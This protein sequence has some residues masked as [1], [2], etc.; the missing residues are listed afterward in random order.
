MEFGLRDAVPDG[1]LA[2][3]GARWIVTQDGTVDM[4][5]DRQSCVGESKE[6]DELVLW[7]NGGALQQAKWQA[8]WQLGTGE[9]STRERKR[10]ELFRDAVGLVVGDPQAS[11]G[12]L[13]VAAWLH[14][15][16]KEA[17]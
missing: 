15:H 10:V 4:V 6:Q 5:P 12:Y 16:V 17:V 7:L 14:V 13:Y 1:A 3:W 2:A 9:L 11:A 8:E